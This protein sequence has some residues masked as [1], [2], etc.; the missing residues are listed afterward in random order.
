MD[1]TIAF[2]VV[3]ACS[4]SAMFQFVA[5]SPAAGESVSGKRA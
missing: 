3:A 4:V 1:F 5:L 2:F